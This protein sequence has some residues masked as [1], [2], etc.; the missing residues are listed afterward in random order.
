MME[1]EMVFEILHVIIYCVFTR[2]II[3]EDF[4]AYSRENLKSYMQVMK[5]LEEL[6][7]LRYNAV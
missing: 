2:L 5:N 3:R 1:T 6:Y 4:N 7:L